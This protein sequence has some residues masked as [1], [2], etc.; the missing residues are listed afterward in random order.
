M[1][2]FCQ[3]RGALSGF[4][5]DYRVKRPRAKVRRTVAEIES[6]FFV[7]DGVVNLELTYFLVKGL[8]NLR[9]T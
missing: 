3:K 2:L 8:D 9:N 5:S 4:V 1:R 6:F 7:H